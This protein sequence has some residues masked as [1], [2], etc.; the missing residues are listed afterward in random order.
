MKNVKN[1]IV[2]VKNTNAI[3]GALFPSHFYLW[4]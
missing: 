2:N 3:S 1:D 4:Q